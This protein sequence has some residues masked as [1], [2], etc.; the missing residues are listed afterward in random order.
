MAHS[1]SPA[2]RQRS[3][4]RRLRS[5]TDWVQHRPS[6]AFLLIGSVSVMPRSAVPTHTDSGPLAVLRAPQ[7]VRLLAAGLL[8]RM[9]AGTAPLALLIFARETMSLTAAG[10]LVGRR[11]RAARWPRR[12][13]VAAARRYRV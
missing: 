9:P 3:R 2:L 10:L 1:G 5:V 7:A 11:G 4:A 13:G 6:T 8:G 12:R